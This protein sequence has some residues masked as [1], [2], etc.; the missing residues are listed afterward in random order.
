MIYLFC[1]QYFST[2]FYKHTD[3]IAKLGAVNSLYNKR[4]L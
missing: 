4:V 1:F 3:V 2:V